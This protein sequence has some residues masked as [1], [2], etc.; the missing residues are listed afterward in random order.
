VRCAVSAL[1]DAAALDAEP[2]HASVDPGQLR[3]AEEPATLTPQATAEIRRVAQKC[4]LL[5]PVVA[6]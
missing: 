4:V 2:L 1:L 5:R 3:L 6:E